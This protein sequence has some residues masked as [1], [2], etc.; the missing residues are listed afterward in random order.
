MHLV[1][2]D[3]RLAP[4]N[5]YQCPPTTVLN[6]A[7]RVRYNVCLYICRPFSCWMEQNLLLGNSP[8]GLWQ[9][10]ERCHCH[11]PT[12]TKDNG[13]ITSQQANEKRTAKVRKAM[14]KATTW[15]PGAFS[16]LA[17]T[18]GNW[19]GF[20]SDRSEIYGE[21]IKNVRVSVPSH[22]HERHIAKD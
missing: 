3:A 21:F 18:Q 16:F 9:Q 17:L 5:T 22:E 10:K 14:T 8:Y 12:P 20:R 4:S 15:N 6:R 13:Y 2:L 1:P 19:F 11:A 7:K